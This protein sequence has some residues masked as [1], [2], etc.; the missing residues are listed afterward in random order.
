M[1]IEILAVD[2]EAPS[3]PTDSSAIVSTAENSSAQLNTTGDID[4]IAERGDIVIAADRVRLLGGIGGSR[5]SSQKQAVLQIVKKV[6]EHHQVTAKELKFAPQCLLDGALHV[7]LQAN[8][9]E[10]CF[11]VPATSLDKHARVISSHVVYKV[12]EDEKRIFKLK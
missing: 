11:E 6:F 8:K 4:N 1:G 12:N 3:A 10:A 9:K 7:E 5:L 2:V